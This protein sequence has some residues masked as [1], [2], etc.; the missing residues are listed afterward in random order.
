MIP[1][2]LLFLIV[3]SCVLIVVGM[4]LGKLTWERAIVLILVAAV[5]FGA[6]VFLLGERG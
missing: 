2:W 6:L 5:V 3:I 1:T 4:L